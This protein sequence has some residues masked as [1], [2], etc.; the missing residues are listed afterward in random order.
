M[1]KRKDPF[2]TEDVKSTQKKKFLP[3]YLF[4]KTFM[5]SVEIKN[6][7]YIF[8]EQNISIDDI[9][10][11]EGGIST[12]KFENSI[13]KDPRR[14][15]D[16]ELAK[17]VDDF[18]NETKIFQKN[19]EPSSDDEEKKTEKSSDS[20]KELEMVR[21][22]LVCELFQQKYK[23]KEIAKTLGISSK[24]VYNIVDKYDPKI[25]STKIQKKSKRLVI[26]QD[27]YNSL[28]QFLQNKNNQLLTLMD[29]KIYLMNQFKLK[30]NQL[31]LQTVSNML[32]RLNYSRKRVRLESQKKN[33]HANIIQRKQVA[34]SFL[35]HIKNGI[36]MIFIDETGFNNNMKPLYGYSKVGERCNVD[37]TNNS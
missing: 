7:Q 20:Y 8:H 25:N 17:Y 36:E 6:T 9:T 28:E 21:D 5:Y 16:N 37:T 23:A 19:L 29:Y 13:T 12:I 3:P 15:E 26:T 35:T 1:S 10:W 22:K 31:S 30:K 24:K 14:Y 18:D 34:R 11:F 27:M 2:A 33:L 4:N 32:R